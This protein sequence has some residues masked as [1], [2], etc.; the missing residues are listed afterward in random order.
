[1]AQK[2]TALE[3]ALTPFLPGGSVEQ[4]CNL[5]REY[6]H[7]LVITKGRVT[8]HGDFRYVPGE[9]YKITINH[10]LNR[11]AF[12]ITLIHELAHLLCHARHG[13][14]VKPH[15]V[16][17]KMCFQELMRPFLKTSILPL[18]IEQS[19]SQYLN[20]PAA[21]TCS[22]VELYKALSLYDRKSHEQIVLVED[23]LEEQ[24]FLYG[25]ER[26]HFIRKEKRRTRIRCIEK[27]TGTEYLFPAIAKVFRLT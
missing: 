1:M 9:R 10:N 3:Q 8:K 17:W 26:R 21:S 18:D 24:E 12:L 5:L 2:T 6:P 11:Y 23:V 15:G 22:D 20:N 7:D 25:K 27:S 16:E 19:L 14:K 13:S 4:V